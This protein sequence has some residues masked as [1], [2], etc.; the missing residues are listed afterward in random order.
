MP[1]VLGIDLGTTYSAVAA[2]GALGKPEILSNRDGERITPSVVLFQGDEVQVGSMAKRAAPTAPDDVVQFVKRQMGDPAWRFINSSGREFT[3]EEVS[4]IIIK[5]LVEDA[6]LATGE[7][8]TDVVV[9]VPAYFDDARRKATMDAGLVAGVNVRRILNEPTAAALSFGL[10]A[11]VSG[12]VLVFD[13]G[14]GTFDVTIMKVGGG[15]FDVVGTLGDRNLGGFDWDNALMEWINERVMESGGPDLLEDDLLVA[16]LRDKAELAKRTL[17]NVAE[18]KVHIAAG[19]FTTSVT[20]T[21]DAFEQATAGLL[22]RAESI[23]SIA[24]DESGVEWTDIDYLLLVGG[25]TR[26]PMVQQMV[27]RVS[28]KEPVKGVNPDEAVA[29]GAAIQ[30]HIVFLED[31]V[32]SGA[33]P[34]TA[35]SPIVITDVTSQSLG[36]AVLDSDSGREVNSIIIPHNSKV[37]AQCRKEFYTVRDNQTEISVRVTEGDDEEIEYVRIV[38]QTL[39]QIPPH[40]EG[41]PVQV[42]MSYDIDGIVHVSVRDLTSGHDL[43]EFEIDREANLDRDAVDQMKRRMGDTEVS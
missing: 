13:L 4:A 38:G 42:T 12:T 35:A 17:S 9:T 3:A 6:R 2:V 8:F 16:D 34:A 15:E 43:G 37:P 39:L 24:L 25:S 21:R 22:G 20:V 10:D 29:L 27:R 31:E 7:D 41:A 18:T 23:L 32:A 28:D 30:G 19:G 14:G 26:M 36:V 5:R 40:P 33:S 11:E 1:G